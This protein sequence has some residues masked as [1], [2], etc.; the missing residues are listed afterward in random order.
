MEYLVIGIVTLLGAGLTLFSG[1]GLGT[2]LMPVF[3][4]F[5]PIEIAIALTAVVHFANNLIKFGFFYKHLN[6]GIILRFGLPSIASSFL[7]AYL[8]NVLSHLTPIY[9][10]S[11]ADK[12]FAITPIKL[13]IAVL[14]IIFSLFELIPRLKAMQF[15]TKYMP[16][17]G[18]LSGFFGGLSGHQGALRSAFLLRAGL[19][20]E[21]FIGTGVVIASLVDISRLTVY[22]KTITEEV[23]SSQITL[24]VIAVLAAFIGVY[25]GNKLLK[26]M[27]IRILQTL[28]A[29]MLILF[30]VLLGAGIL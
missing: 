6:W 27:T 26:K 12:Y 19:S 21:V 22:S 28:V 4:L 1:F 20:K 30:S 17:G 15:N 16:L 29:S 24:L 23:S 18:L 13:T 5:F 14:L 25:A 9:T 7:G 2:L 11:L 8:L 3:A 10:Y